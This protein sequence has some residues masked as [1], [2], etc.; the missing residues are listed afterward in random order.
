[1]VV[2]GKKPDTNFSHYGLVDANGDGTVDSVDALTEQARW[3][4]DAP[5]QIAMWKEAQVKIL[6]DV[7]AV[8]IIRLM[9][10][11]PMKSYVDLGYD[12]EFSWQTYSPQINEKTRLLAH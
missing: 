7:A 10:A 6:Q 9:Y 4:L 12:L 2:N 3:E 5:K 11:F 1:V 8:P